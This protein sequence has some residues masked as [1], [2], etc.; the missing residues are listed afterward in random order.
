MI[1]GIFP[2]LLAFSLSAHAANPPLAALQIEIWPEY[3][4]PGALVIY[5][6]E[7]AQSVRLPAEVALR[8]P[9]TSGGPAAVAYATEE[10]G[11][12]LNLAH[13][14]ETA[15]NFIVVHIRPPQRFFHMEFYDRMATDKPQREYRYA[16]PGDMA[17]EKVSV[18]VKEPA[19]SSNLAVQPKL[20]LTGQS[21]DGLT[22]RAT[23]LGALKAGEQLPIEIRYTKTDP[24]PSTEIVAAPVVAATAQPEAP[25]QPIWPLVLVAGGAVVLIGA[26]TVLFWRRRRVAPTAVAS[27]KHFCP[28]C[29]RAT[30]AGDRFCPNCGAALG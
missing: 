18:L 9:A 8:I 30:K 21:P 29:G 2:L 12:L 17:V 27:S 20:D 19:G 26:L 11:K 25:Q 1:R 23:Q 7:L 15:G 28:K 13:Q 6:G 5:K 24:R 4:R 3:D 10:S 14:V 22:H 16:W